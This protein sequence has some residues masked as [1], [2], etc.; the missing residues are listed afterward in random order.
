[1][2]SNLTST[3]EENST[4]EWLPDRKEIYFVKLS[5]CVIFTF[6]LDKYVKTNILYDYENKCWNCVK[7]IISNM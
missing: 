7:W 2:S 6:I 1:M 3:R 4:L 5:F